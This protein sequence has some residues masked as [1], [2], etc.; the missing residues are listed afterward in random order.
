MPPRDFILLAILRTFPR[1]FFEFNFFDVDDD[2]RFF[3]VIV[4]LEL[5]FDNVVVD[6]FV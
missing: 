6:N 5:F 3:V 4:P 1:R 2:K